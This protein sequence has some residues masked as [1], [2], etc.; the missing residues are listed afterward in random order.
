MKKLAL[1]LA[2]TAA[3]AGQ[4]IAADMPMKA[5]RPMAAPVA[6][7]NW[8]GCNIY[9]GIGYGWYQAEGRELA[10]ATGVVTATNGDT[11]GKGWL[12]QVGAGCDYQFGGPMGNWVIGVFGDYTFSNVRGDHIGAP[13]TTSIGTLNQDYS[14]AVVGRIGYLVTPTFLT[15]FNAGYT[16][17]HFKDTVYFNALPAPPPFTV[18]TGTLLPGAT[19]QGWFIGSGFE[20]AIN[21]LPVQGLFLKTEYR[22]S[23]FDRN[24]LNI[25]T[26]ATRTPVG[27]AETVKPFTQSITSSLVW[28]FNWGGQGVVAKY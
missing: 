10:F 6:A 17:T 5:A 2:A 16:E 1:A 22:Y 4:A 24:R 21:F 27:L 15:Y 7:Y 19:Y 23:E 8:T 12:G 26:T 9:G 28:R 18:A 25:L 20:Y 13:V 14:W 3:F 11:G